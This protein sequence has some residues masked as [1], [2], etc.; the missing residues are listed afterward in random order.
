MDLK[1]ENIVPVFGYVVAKRLELEK[2]ESK[3]LD[4]STDDSE[5]IAEVINI[6]LGNPTPNGSYIPMQVRPTSIIIYEKGS[7]KPFKLDGVEYLFID[8]KG[9]LGTFEEGGKR[10]G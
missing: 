9:I 1:I 4:L 5:N 3:I 2:K 6:G 8:Q 7:E 10:H